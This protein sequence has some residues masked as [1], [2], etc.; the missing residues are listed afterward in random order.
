M[1]KLCLTAMK[2]FFRTQVILTR[3][4][5]CLTQAK[6]ARKLFME[7]RSYAALESGESGC[8]ALTLALFLIYCC[9]DPILFLKKLRVALDGVTQNAAYPPSN[10]R[11]GFGVST[12]FACYR[13]TSLEGRRRIS[14]LPPLSYFPGARI[15]ELL[16]PMWPK[17]ELAWLQKC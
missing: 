8:G 13:N 11:A 1:K 2:D 16:R 17:A 14:D 15:Y 12:P 6:M 10:R 7:D 4:R 3:D 5:L 9:D